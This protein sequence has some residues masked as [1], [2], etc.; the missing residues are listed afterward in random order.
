MARPGVSFF[1]VSKAATAIVDQGFTPTVDRVREILGTGSKSTI[2]PLLKQWKESNSHQK[3]NGELPQQLMDAVKSLYQTSRSIA[4]ERIQE[5]TDNCN[6][7]LN[8]AQNQLKATNQEN[9]ALKQELERLKEEIKQEQQKYKQLF[10]DWNSLSDTL[11]AK[12]Q[13]NTTLTEKNNQLLADKEEL[14]LEVKTVRSHFEHYQQQIA[15]DRLIEREQF[16]TTLLSNQEHTRN[17]QSQAD[18]LKKANQLLTQES[19]QLKEKLDDTAQQLAKEKQQL[20]SV[21]LE[22][23]ATQT[24]NEQWQQRFEAESK[25]SE[26][27][28]EKLAA[29]E[30][31]IA[32]YTQKITM[33]ETSNR[34]QEQQIQTVHKRANQY[35]TQKDQLIKENAELTAKVTTLAQKP[36]TD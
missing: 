24:D 15:E 20:S 14:K 19:S 17:V 28:K 27:L 11:K 7:K 21:A 2:S 9:T 3:D 34:L 31:Q 6:N 10:D 29:K 32:T 16:Q 18:D 36:N 4:D 22:L 5:I 12:S 35:E 26:Q 25:Q 30:D 33:L 13:A 8:D 23:K 1:D